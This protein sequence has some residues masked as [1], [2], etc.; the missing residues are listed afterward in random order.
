MPREAQEIANQ[1]FCTACL[2][3]Y[4]CGGRTGLFRNCRV[5]GEQ[6]GKPKNRCQWIV[7]LVGRAR[8]K[9][10]K[11]NQ[12]FRLHELRLQ[13]FQILDGLL[14]LSKKPRAVAVGHSRPQEDN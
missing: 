11:R 7:D 3:T 5:V 1:S 14:R 9:L 13:P 8:G 2:V 6:I 12:F 4:F 10:A